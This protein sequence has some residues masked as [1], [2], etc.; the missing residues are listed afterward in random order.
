MKKQ[1][2][3]FKT[4]INTIRHESSQTLKKIEKIASKDEVKILEREIEAEI[5]KYIGDAEQLAASKENDIKNS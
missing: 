1:V 4:E 5:K 2:E 3:R